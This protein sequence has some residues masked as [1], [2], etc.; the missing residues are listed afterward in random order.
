M[1]KISFR[2]H[3]NPKKIVATD[4]T[5]I[6][7]FGERS[8]GKT[9]GF[10]SL[11]FEEFEKSGRPSAY[12]RRRAESLKSSNM[13]TFLKSHETNG[14]IP[15][16]EFARYRGGS[17]YSGITVEGKALYMDTPFLDC[18]AISQDENAKGTTSNCNYKY[19]IFDEFLTRSVYLNNEFVRF[20]NLLSTLIRENPDCTIVLL[21][22]TVN[23]SSI[24][25]SEM[26]LSHVRKQ[27]QG[28]IELYQCLNELGDYTQIAVEY[29][30]SN[31]NS[32]KRQT[33]KYFCFD[34]PEI[35]MITSGVWETALYPHITWDSSKDVSL[36]REV[37]I[38]YDGYVVNVE[39]RKNPDF[40]FYCFFHEHTKEIDKRAKV[41]FSD[42]LVQDSRYFYDFKNTKNGKR[43]LS[44]QQ[45]KK[46][47]YST[48]FCG[49]V[50]R[51]Y[52]KNIAMRGI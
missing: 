27:K 16:G 47:Y 49:E 17:W 33:N 24:Y 52:L 50:V 13:K 15:C 11:A 43:I 23:F 4:S 45:Q 22:N 37:Y 26:G 30:K 44:L 21:G 38:E 18:Y 19:I 9:Y 31:P 6:V 8:N 5:Y 35:K 25:F 46:A 34:S 48:N 29:C 42:K 39:Y 40:G 32:K 3:Y 36:Y 20:M 7:C 14:H 28:T 51:N 2:G 12:I 1:K 41:I 10:L